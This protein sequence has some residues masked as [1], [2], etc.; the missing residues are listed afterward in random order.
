[1]PHDRP[2]RTGWM[3]EDVAKLLG[4]RFVERRDV[5]AWEFA[6]RWE[7]DRSPMTLKDIQQHLA[8][9]R[10]LGHYMLSQENKTRLF[11]F[12]IDLRKTAYDAEDNE[13][14]PRSA[15][16]DKK[17]PRRS[18]LAIELMSMASGLAHRTHRLTDC[19][20]AIALSGGKG[21]H[22][23][24]FTGS[25]PAAESRAVCHA[26]LESYDCFAP[27]R[28]ENFWQ[29]DSAYPNIEIETFPKQ[30]VLDGKDL[31]NLMRLPL[32]VH[33]K[34]GVRSAFLRIPEESERDRPFR[35]MAAIDALNGVLP[36]KN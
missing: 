17:D 34:T 11:A 32:G 6:N 10:T 21:L 36:W 28:G 23:Y 29:H 12:D 7:P 4:Q 22:V 27:V 35:K 5:K 3:T 8:G 31:G 25:M 15:Y 16:A 24:C 19:H 2:K 20:V 1:M 9:D 30:D 26:I 18:R 33:R 14:S 13:W